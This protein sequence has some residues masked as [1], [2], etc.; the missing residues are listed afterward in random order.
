MQ[1]RNWQRGPG[2]FEAMNL[3]FRKGWELVDNPLAPHPL[4]LV[5]RPGMPHHFRRS[6]K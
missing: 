6:K 2:L 4:W 3:W 5:Y 1:E